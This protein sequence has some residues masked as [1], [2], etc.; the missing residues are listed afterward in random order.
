MAS[1]PY[2]D[3]DPVLLTLGPI[4]I[5]WYGL[6]YVA[7]FVV[8]GVVMRS[9]V[10]RWEL[11]LTDDDLLDIVLAAV[12][13]LVLGARIGYVLFYGAGSYWDDPLS[14]VAFWD[15]GMSFHGGLIGILIAGLS[16]RG[17]RASPCFSSTTS[18][19]LARRSASSSAESRT[20]STASC[21]AA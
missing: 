11:E 19:P 18:A 13:G 20:S 5:R 8:A 14:V 3:I 17:A 15:G 6:A 4:A 2:P 12:I 1:I 7:G 21:G 10:R 9:L 16:W